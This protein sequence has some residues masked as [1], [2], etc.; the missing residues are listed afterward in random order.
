MKK[1][2]KIIQ[3]GTNRWAYLIPNKMIYD[4]AGVSHIRQTIKD[5]ENGC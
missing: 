3:L 1:W 4:V 5:Y 2:L